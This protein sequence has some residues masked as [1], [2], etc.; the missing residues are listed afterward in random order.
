MA[1]TERDEAHDFLWQATLL[2]PHERESAQPKLEALLRAAESRGRRAGLEQAAKEAMDAGKDAQSACEPDVALR[3]HEFARY[4]CGLASGAAEQER[5]RT[6]A[7]D[8]TAELGAQPREGTASQANPAGYWETH[9]PQ[10]GHAGNRPFTPS[11]SA[12]PA[13]RD[14]AM[15][16]RART[17]LRQ[18]FGQ[19]CHPDAV[20]SESARYTRFAASECATRDARIADTERLYHEQCERTNAHRERVAELEREV[21]R[22]KLTGQF[23]V[24]FLSDETR[25]RTA[26]LA[27][28]AGGEARENV[29]AVFDTLAQDPTV[30][31]EDLAMVA[32]ERPAP[33]PATGDV[34]ERAAMDWYGGTLDLRARN[35]AKFLSERFRKTLEIAGKVM[36]LP[37][38][39]AGAYAIAPISLTVEAQ[40]ALSEL[41]AKG[42]GSK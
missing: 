8:A 33:P 30:S 41:R 10:S 42:R 22:L 11:P 12:S 3:F 24:D 16:E 5:Q 18:E 39:K 26:P 21:Q 9:P 19:L 1:T 15:V 20:E 38:D 14:A 36:I 6:E 2:N 4:M 37:Y 29:K 23:A 7:N 31:M 13:A 28:P 32:K 34:F 35:L 25:L 27:S 17:F 40:A